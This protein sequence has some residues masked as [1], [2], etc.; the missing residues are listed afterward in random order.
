LLALRAAA[1]ST[2]LLRFTA[3]TMSLRSGTALL[4]LLLVALLFFLLTDR[5]DVVPDLV[6]DQVRPPRFRPRSSGSQ[7]LPWRAPIEFGIAH[8]PYHVVRRKTLSEPKL[9]LADTEGSIVLF[10]TIRPMR[11]PVLINAF[12]AGHSTEPALRARSDRLHQ[13]LG[14]DLT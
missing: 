14:R 3:L 12:K 13:V 8:A 6:S 4:R 2:L 10:E 9:T 7:H 5:D 11:V 1:A